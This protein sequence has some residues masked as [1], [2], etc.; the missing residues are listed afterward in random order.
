[1]LEEKVLFYLYVAEHF[2]QDGYDSEQGVDAFPLHAPT[3]VVSPHILSVHP[4]VDS[5][6][7]NLFQTKALVGPNNSCKVIIDGGS[8]RNLPS[9]VVCQAEFD[10]FVTSQAILYTMVE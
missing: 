3:I 1:M 10:L 9:K 8:C 6:C 2:S 5:Q 7:C 4:I